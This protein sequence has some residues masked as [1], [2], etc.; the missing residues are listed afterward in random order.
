[1][2]GPLANVARF[3]V[4]WDG[5]GEAG[6]FLR[7]EIAPLTHEAEGGEIVLTRAVGGDRT[8]FDWFHSER[9][10]RR[11]RTRDLRVSLLDASGGTV[12][13]LAIA[14]A[15][16]VRY[17]LSTLDAMGDGPV[18]EALALAYARIDRKG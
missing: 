18:L 10:A 3:R 9:G 15:R 12:A 16:P 13:A 6:G 4:D 7:V 2:T 5:N 14:G 17:S 8:L 11:P 1:M